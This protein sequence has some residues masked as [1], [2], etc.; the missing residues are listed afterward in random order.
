MSTEKLN[1]RFPLEQTNLKLFIGLLV[2]LILVMLVFF[3]LSVAEWLSGPRNSAGLILPIVIFLASI[4]IVGQSL[5]G[6]KIYRGAISS[7]EADSYVVTVLPDG[8]SVSTNTNQSQF[9]WNDVARVSSDKELLHSGLLAREIY[10]ALLFIHDETHL[11]GEFAMRR[12]LRRTV[13]RRALFYPFTLPGMTVVPVYFFDQKDAKRLFAAAQESHLQYR[14]S[15]P[16]Q[17]DQT[18]ND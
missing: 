15:H 14:A 12:A 10:A 4:P 1:I 17:K 2:F 5:R 16:D 7:G 18:R 9:S 11:P 13:L 6:L 8:V 3:A